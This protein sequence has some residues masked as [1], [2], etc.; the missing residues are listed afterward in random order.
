MTPVETELIAQRCRRCRRDLPLTAEYFN[1]H[2]WH[3]SGFREVCRE[4]RNRVRRKKGR[5]RYGRAEKT[6]LLRMARDVLVGRCSA[7]HLEVYRVLASNLGGADGIA[8]ALAQLVSSPKTKPRTAVTILN[9]VVAM[10]VRLEEAAEALA[11]RREQE[12]AQKSKGEL[13]EHLWELTEQLVRAKGL[14]IVPDDGR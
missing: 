8:A 7:G 4:C 10:S 6:L 2:S 12:L 11:A 14:K 5:E 13:Q 3:K 1:R 9:S